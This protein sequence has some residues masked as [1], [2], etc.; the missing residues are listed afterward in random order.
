MEIRWN[1]IILMVLFVIVL[2]LVLK[3][4]PTMAIFLVG[5]KDIGPGHTTDEKTAGLI[6]FALVSMLIVAIV[7]VLTSRNSK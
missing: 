5:M 1:N 7:K 4:L 2:L 3:L 6:A